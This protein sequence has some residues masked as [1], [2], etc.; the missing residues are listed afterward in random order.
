MAVQRGHLHTSTHTS[1]QLSF[2]VGN[3]YLHFIAEPR[4]ELMTDP[5]KDGLVSGKQKESD[6]V[7]SAKPFSHPV[8]LPPLNEVTW[9][10]SPVT[11]DR[12]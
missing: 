4:D 11:A 3:F 2:E 1:S 8:P 6:V 12:F 5:R 10:Q 7:L 9:E